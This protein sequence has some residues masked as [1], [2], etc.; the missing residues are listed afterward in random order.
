M[1]KQRPEPYT[2]TAYSDALLELVLSRLKEQ[3]F[4]P[5]VTEAVDKYLIQWTEK[6]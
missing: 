4:T 5:I 3:G 2:V 6:P 1:A